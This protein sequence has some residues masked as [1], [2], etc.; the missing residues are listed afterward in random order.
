MPDTVVRVGAS[1][2]TEVVEA[3]RELVQPGSG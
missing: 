1:T 2:P 3:I